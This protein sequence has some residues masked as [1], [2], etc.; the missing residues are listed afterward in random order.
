MAIATFT[1]YEDA[2]RDDQSG[3][4]V[5]NHTKGQREAY[6]R[7][8]PE[9]VGKLPDVRDANEKPTVAAPTVVGG[10]T[11]WAEPRRAGLRPIRRLC[12]RR[13]PGRSQSTTRRCAMQRMRHL[14]AG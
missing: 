3:I 14:I 11:W 5:K 8:H 7:R 13:L 12:A 4:A 2:L 6:L 1:Q 9:L 10:R